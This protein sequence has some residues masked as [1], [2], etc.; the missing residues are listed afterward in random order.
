MLLLTHGPEMKCVVEVHV[1]V[2][3]ERPNEPP[4][5]RCGEASHGPA[6]SPEA[7]RRGYHGPKEVDPIEHCRQRGW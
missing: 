6:S 3:V 4:D 2:D 7:K 5:D 1:Y